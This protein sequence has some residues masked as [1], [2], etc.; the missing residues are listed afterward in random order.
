MVNGDR[1]KTLRDKNQMTQ[2][3]LAAKMRIPLKLL[4]EIEADCREVTPKIFA[5][6]VEVLEVSDDDISSWKHIAVGATGDKVRA[7]RKNKGLNLEELGTLTGLSPTYISEVERGE[8][9]A[10]ISA[11]RAIT[12]VFEIPISLFIGNKRKQSVVG[13]K[14]KNARMNRGMTQKELAELTG[15]STAM[16]THLENGKVQASLDSIEKISESLGISICYLILEQEEVEEMI[17]A[18][19]PEMREILFDKNVQNVIGSICT[20][21]KDEMVRALNYIHLIKNP[22]IK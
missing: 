7:L 2:E 21:T 13:Q 9:V 14:L 10:S 16:I 11:L 20:F 1:I 5:R 22:Y 4:Q 12:E 3:Q 8:K 15:L 6:L 18:I 17:G 19:T